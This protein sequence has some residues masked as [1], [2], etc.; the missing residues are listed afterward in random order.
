VLFELKCVI[1][2]FDRLIGGD[3][4]FND[5][6][7]LSIFR[8]DGGLLICLAGPPLV[9]GLYSLFAFYRYISG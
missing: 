2:A 9:L 4:T 7:V 5:L 1:S 8:F 3:L 6:T